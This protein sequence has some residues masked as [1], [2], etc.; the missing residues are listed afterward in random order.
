M[1]LQRHQS[2]GKGGLVRVPGREPNWRGTLMARRWRPS[3]LENTE[4]NPTPTIVSIVFWAGL[5]VLTFVLLLLGYG[6]G[7]WH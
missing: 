1:T 5:A 2:D 4:M 3:A 7:F 6:T